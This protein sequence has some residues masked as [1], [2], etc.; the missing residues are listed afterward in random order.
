MGKRKRLDYRKVV[1]NKKLPILTLDSRWH[2][3]FPDDKKTA[4]IKELENKVNRLLKTQGKIVNDIKDM[5]KLKRS[6][7]SDIVVNM[8]IK[9][10]ITG[11]AKEKKLDQSKRFINELNEK[12][13]NAS[14]RLSELPYKIREANEELLS[15]SIK[16]CYDRIHDNQEELK[17]ISEW[18]QKTRMELKEK[19]LVKYDLESSY[20]LMYTYLYDILG[21]DVI[22]II[23]DSNPIKE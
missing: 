5:K 15:E 21:S 18:I 20:N 13:D 22:D 10:D 7:I 19:I 9:N 2:E 16:Y 3:I 6:L 8:D 12:I 14:E 17:N 11:K 1:K 4:K 23:D